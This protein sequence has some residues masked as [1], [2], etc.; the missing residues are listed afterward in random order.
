[1]LKAE[2]PNTC[3]MDFLA[4][5]FMYLLPIP[6]L[7]NFPS[8]PAGLAGLLV[9]S[10][11]VFKVLTWRD[12]LA[13]LPRSRK[14]SLR[15]RLYGLY[16]ISFN[17][18]TKAWFRIPFHIHKAAAGFHRSSSSPAFYHF[19]RNLAKQSSSIGKLWLALKWATWHFAP[20]GRGILLR[21]AQPPS[22]TAQKGLPLRAFLRITCNPLWSFMCG[23]QREPETG[24]P[25]SCIQFFLPKGNR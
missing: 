1:M 18:C 15:I 17:P 25:Q 7:V 21:A 2:H 9:L 4:V 16:K 19:N 11:V 24:D 14:P 12:E 6:V 5:F 3:N 13:Q 10:H 8:L 22:I 23:Y 20:A